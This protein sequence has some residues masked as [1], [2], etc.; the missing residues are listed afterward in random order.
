MD[1]SQFSP[2]CWRREWILDSSS[3]VCDEEEGSTS[4]TPESA[5]LGGSEPS[6]QKIKIFSVY[7]SKYY[8]QTGGLLVS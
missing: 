1:L 4:E 2:R 3:E 6:K 7:I 5:G 8:L